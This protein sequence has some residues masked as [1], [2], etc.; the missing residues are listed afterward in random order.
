M[1]SVPALEWN[2]ARGCNLSCEGCLT[3]SDFPYTEII[4][5]ETLRDWYSNW[6]HRI[7]PKSLAVLGGEPLLN[8]Q[9]LDIVSM[10]RDMWDKQ[11]NE[12]FELVTN[13][14]LLHRFPDLPKVLADT[15][16]VLAISIHDDS[17]EY[18]KKVR[19]IKDLVNEWAEKY[20]IKIRY[21]DD[22]ERKETL[23]KK[24]YIGKGLDIRP[25]NDN[26]IESSWKNCITGQK[27]WQLWRGNIYKCPLVAYLPEHKEKFGLHEAWDRYLEEYHPLTPTASDDE[28]INFFERKAETC[29][30]M[31]P[32]TEQQKF[33]K[34]DP[35]KNQ[36]IFKREINERIKIQ[37]KRK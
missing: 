1:I 10:T 18:N 28:I 35:I 25:F 13:G 15:D 34:P 32:A 16:C 24:T 4:D 3:F 23:W 11:N 31:C 21:Y 6:C 19:E 33:N 9:V 22:N 37:N 5:I 17:E 12:Y 7:S 29:C 27:C 8:K 30:G 2:I 26:D 36:K 14:F 20:K